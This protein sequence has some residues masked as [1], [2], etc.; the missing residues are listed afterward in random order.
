VFVFV[1][2]FVFGFVFGFGLGVTVDRVLDDLAQR[3]SRPEAH[4][5]PA[6]L[7]RVRARTKG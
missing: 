5:A 3:R 4:H 7:V 6:V 2:V 1:F